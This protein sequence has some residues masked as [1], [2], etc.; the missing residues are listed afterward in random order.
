MKLNCPRFS[1]G[2]GQHLG[3]RDPGMG[4]TFFDIG[5]GIL[6]SPGVG[7]GLKCLCMIRILT[8]HSLGMTTKEQIRRKFN[9]FWV[10][11]SHCL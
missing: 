11:K 4:D 6:F 5:T 8:A 3:D 2:R 1:R 9:S 7:V 10:L